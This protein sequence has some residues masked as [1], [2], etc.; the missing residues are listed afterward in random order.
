MGGCGAP[1]YLYLILFHGGSK[2]A[3]HL[4]AT[5]SYGVVYALSHLQEFLGR[6]HTF[7]K[8]S[9]VTV[10]NQAKEAVKGRLELV[11]EY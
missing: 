4:G 5:L 3:F 10:L 7:C 2:V 11:R 9:F 8:R 6:L 1:N